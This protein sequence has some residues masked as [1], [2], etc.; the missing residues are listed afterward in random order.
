[1]KKRISLTTDQKS[2]LGKYLDPTQK[3]AK[4]KSIKGKSQKFELF[5]VLWNLINRSIL[6]CLKTPPKR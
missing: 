6:P 3:Q 4:T 5:K 1:M 2:E